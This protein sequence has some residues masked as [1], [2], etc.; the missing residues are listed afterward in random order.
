MWQV[1][2]E[3]TID[4]PESL[5]ES[6]NTLLFELG[7][8]NHTEPPFGIPGTMLENNRIERVRVFTVQSALDQ[9]LTIVQNHPEYINVIEVTE[10]PTP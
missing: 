8:Q 1:R 5:R 6:V 3:S 7:E 2:T 9:F 10:L 4:L